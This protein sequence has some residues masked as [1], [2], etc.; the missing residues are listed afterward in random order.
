M[1]DHQG[2]QD[3]TRDR[4][5]A[6]NLVWRLDHRAPAGGPAGERF[7]G[8]PDG[9]L[10]IPRMV[11]QRVNQGRGYRSTGTPPRAA[12]A[13]PGPVTS[14]TTLPPGSTSAPLATTLGSC[15][16]TEPTTTAAAG[17]SRLPGR[18]SALRMSCSCVQIR[19]AQCREALRQNV[20][21]LGDDLRAGASATHLD[22]ILHL[23]AQVIPDVLVVRHLDPGV[24]VSSQPRLNADNVRNLVVH[25]PPRALGRLREV[26]IA[27]AAGEIDNG[28]RCVGEGFD[29]VVKPLRRCLVW[30]HA[31]SLPSAWT[32]LSSKDDRT[33]A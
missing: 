33:V 15:V 8:Q 6:D 10:T 2:F 22:G 12:T 32:V 31:A 20:L 19:T 23:L 18:P 16:M 17:E 30:R 28:L 4:L 25:R 26:V 3:A 27:A 1:G 13:E 14:M 9:Y 24:L 7:G 11:Q 21:E 5:V 29:T